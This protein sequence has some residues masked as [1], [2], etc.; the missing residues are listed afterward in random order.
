MA[1]WRQ[2]EANPKL[3]SE[4]NSQV[5]LCRGCHTALD[6][7]EGGGGVSSNKGMVRGTGSLSNINEFYK[8]AAKED[9]TRGD[10]TKSGDDK[11]WLKDP[12]TTRFL[13]SSLCVFVCD[14][15]A[16]DFGVKYKFPVGELFSR[17]KRI[18]S[19]R[20]FAIDDISRSIVTPS[21]KECGSPYDPSVYDSL[22]L[23]SM[24][25]PIYKERTN[26]HVSRLFHRS[27]SFEG[28]ATTNTKFL[29]V[30]N[31]DHTTKNVSS[32][33]IGGENEEYVRFIK[34]LHSFSSAKSMYHALRNGA[35][36][37]A[38]D[39][40]RILNVCEELEA[41]LDVSILSSVKLEA[42]RTGMGRLK[43][44]LSEVDVASCSEAADDFDQRF[45]ELLADHFGPIKPRTGYY[46][47]LSG[48]EFIGEAAATTTAHSRDNKQRAGSCFSTSSPP[49]APP[50]RKQ[51]QSLSS[52][53][54]YAPYLTVPVVSLGGGGGDLKTDDP[55]KSNLKQ[56][57]FLPSS[58]PYS[59]YLTVPVVSLGG[60]GGDLKT[61]DPNKSKGS[62]QRHSSSLPEKILRKIF[63]PILV[64]FEL[65][66]MSADG[67]LRHCVQL[68]ETMGVCEALL[69]MA[70]V[71]DESHHEVVGQTFLFI[72]LSTFPGMVISAQTLSL[73]EELIS[74]ILSN[75]HVLMNDEVLRSLLDVTPITLES[76]QLVKKCLSP[77]PPSQLLKFYIPVHLVS[78][79]KSDQRVESA[80]NK[81]YLVS[82]GWDLLQCEL[83][84]GGTSP[85]IMFQRIGDHDVIVVEPDNDSDDTTRGG[86][87]KVPYWALLSVMDNNQAVHELQLSDSVAPKQHHKVNNSPDN[88]QTGAGGGATTSYRSSTVTLYAH[89]TIHLPSLLPGVL[90][91]LRETICQAV[92]GAVK[93]VNQRLLLDSLHKTKYASSLL[94]PSNS[95][96]QQQQQQHSNHSASSPTG[97]IGGGE[98]GLSEDQ[99]Q[100]AASGS[101]ERNELLTHQENDLRPGCFS[102]SLKFR[103]QFPLYNRIRDQALER[104]RAAALEGFLITNRSQLYVYRDSSG[105]IFYLSLVK[106]VISG[107]ATGPH[108]KGEKE[109][110]FLVLSAFGVDEVGDDVAV[111]LTRVIEQKL[112][113]CSSNFL[114]LLLKRNPNFHLTSLDLEVVKSGGNSGRGLEA[115]ATASCGGEVGGGDDHHISAPPAAC[116]SN[117]GSGKWTA[118]LFLPKGIMDVPLFFLYLRQVMCASEL[119]NP[120]F[121]TT[122]LET[123]LLSESGSGIADH[124]NDR[125]TDGGLGSSTKR[126]SSHPR[127]LLL[128]SMAEESKTCHGPNDG[129]RTDSLLQQALRPC[130]SD[131]ILLTP[132]LFTFYINPSVSGLGHVTPCFARCQSIGKGI[133]IINLSPITMNGDVEWDLPSNATFKMGNFESCVDLQ[134]QCEDEIRS[135]EGEVWPPLSNSGL[136]LNPDFKGRTSFLQVV[137]PTTANSNGVGGG[138]GTATELDLGYNKSPSS[139]S[140]TPSCDATAATTC[141]T[142]T[143]FLKN[144]S[145]NQ[146]GIRVEVDACGAIDLPNLLNLIEMN[147]DQA[148]VDYWIER[149][150]LLNKMTSIMRS[151]VPPDSGIEEPLSPIKRIFKKMDGSCNNSNYKNLPGDHQECHVEVCDGLL[152]CCPPLPL[153]PQSFSNPNPLNGLHYIQQEQTNHEYLENRDE[154]ESNNYSKHHTTVFT[155]AKDCISSSQKH[156]P[157]DANIHQLCDPLGKLMR[158]GQRLGNPTIRGVYL[159]NPLPNWAVYRVLK[160]CIQTLSSCLHVSL[161]LSLLRFDTSGSCEVVKALDMETLRMMSGSGQPPK[162]FVGFFGLRLPN[163]ECKASPIGLREPSLHS[164]HYDT[165]SQGRILKSPSLTSL[166]SS[167]GSDFTSEMHPP[168]FFPWAIT[169]EQLKE[170]ESTPHPYPSPLTSTEDGGSI[171]SFAN[172]KSKISLDELFNHERVVLQRRVFLVLH[173]SSRAQSLEVYNLHHVQAERVCEAV[174]N[175]MSAA[176]LQM[177]AL[178]HVVCQ[179]AGRA[180]PFT[181]LYPRK[182]DLVEGTGATINNASEQQHHVTTKLLSRLNPKQ[183]RERQSAGH[184]GT[185]ALYPEIWKRV[186]SH[187][188]TDS[189]AFSSKLWGMICAE[190]FGGGRMKFD[191]SSSVSPAV[192]GSSQLKSSTEG[193]G[194]K[195]DVSKKSI[196]AATAAAARHRGRHSSTRMN[197]L[198]SG[199]GNTGSVYPPSQVNKSSPPGPRSN[200]P[201]AVSE[202]IPRTDSPVFLLSPSL[203][204][205]SAWRRHVRNCRISPMSLSLHYDHRLGDDTVMNSAGT[206][207]LT[208]SATST[209]NVIN[210]VGCLPIVSIAKQMETLQCAI[211]KENIEA[212]SL[213]KMMPLTWEGLQMLHWTNVK[214]KSTST[215]NITTCDTVTGAAAPSSQQH[216]SNKDKKNTEKLV[217]DDENRIKHDDQNHT[218]YIPNATVAE[219]LARNARLLDVM[220]FPLPMDTAA[221]FEPHYPPS[222]FYHHQSSN[223]TLGFPSRSLHHCDTSINTKEKE[224]EEKEE[225]QLFPTPCNNKHQEEGIGES[226]NRVTQEDAVV[227]KTGH[228][229]TTGLLIG[230]L[231]DLLQKKWGHKYHFQKLALACPPQVNPQIYYHYDYREML[232]CVN[233][234]CVC[235]ITPLKQNQPVMNQCNVTNRFFEVVTVIDWGH[236]S[237]RSLIRVTG[238]LK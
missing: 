93:I 151:V 72:F 10:E 63:P 125:T 79:P 184:T 187:A 85:G 46:A 47:Y 50:D 39:L 59:P 217:V 219:S 127:S 193:V 145:T 204:G 183:G 195:R 104:V 206:T 161:D 203:G 132:G 211:A 60:G 171:R 94:I 220:V 106:E 185:I 165:E 232:L 64:R 112:D 57:Q 75:I 89:V 196:V 143:R 131:L 163:C 188:S 83:L 237:S 5:V 178:E 108:E 236:V 149:I 168:A 4:E 45:F 49:K 190:R 208:L 3:G 35:S 58:V 84:K 19:G 134:K 235:I 228:T 200:G 52:S 66:R 55:N 186:V 218:W 135:L 43:S 209:T 41:S 179:N 233:A 74:N 110:S 226:H 121:T 136:N 28:S 77:L 113:E 9:V 68:S 78:L 15:K 61:D 164:S 109:K 221:A 129:N 122:K 70:V 92:V 172:E 36:V 160:D 154:N 142:S 157:L 12:H 51:Q 212:Q 231:F 230:G 192:P 37:C 182:C 98:V 26:R 42:L 34:E 105:S 124:Y 126:H 53:I 216:R 152:L 238:W 103:C 117:S 155:E 82:T 31:T 97:S 174:L 189:M 197:A 107:V 1:Q 101:S 148:L 210:N 96:L 146:Y 166:T 86:G 6:N 8:A 2:Y 65:R 153:L 170:A 30:L 76:L 91:T 95:E 137:N 150:L 24:N 20:G 176:K 118:Q 215:T 128:P 199:G 102:C 71:D 227:C 167:A 223:G 114:S 234:V 141:D 207:T 16:S 25:E 147:I 177:L 7:T 90:D 56:H 87:Y 100:R 17:V 173:L 11:E 123:E 201:A 99:K 140:C 67:K 54:S 169:A 144:G 13:P 62:S 73:Q 40:K 202:K 81:A 48:A 194:P 23:D 214:K 175:V 229:T 116:V 162:S 158:A 191:H 213:S 139:S 80:G 44:S 224:K 205:R 180:P 198:H 130:T 18:L 111:H 32:N 225:D 27:Y 120:L 14:V 69:Q 29:K 222:T 115:A 38:G 138:G 33:V 119:V 181:S 159:C 88:N 21:D 156:V 22:S 133:A